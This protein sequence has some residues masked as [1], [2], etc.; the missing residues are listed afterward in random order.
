MLKHAWF[1][2]A[3]LV[4]PG[5]TAVAAAGDPVQAL[6]ST[7]VAFVAMVLG[8]PAQALGSTMVAFVAMVLVVVQLV[9]LC[10]LCFGRK[11]M[12][13]SVNVEVVAFEASAES[14]APP[15]G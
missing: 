6:G 15:H 1:G 13:R 12:T 7:M 3:V 2:A 8:D 11:N 4:V 10:S 9:A 14:T 5:C